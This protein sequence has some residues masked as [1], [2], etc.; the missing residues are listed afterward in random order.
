M[1]K[2]DVY[3]MQARGKERVR[4][5]LHDTEKIPRELMFLGRNMNIVR[6][7]NKALG[8]LVNRV[9]IM[10]SFAARGSALSEGVVRRSTTVNLGNRVASWALLWSQSTPLPLLPQP[11]STQ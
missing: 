8:S 9:G 10:A 1:T 6:A 5:L 2:A 7:N 3:A 4:S 11:S